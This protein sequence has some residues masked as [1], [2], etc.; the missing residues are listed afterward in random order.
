MI[1]FDDYSI[2][3]ISDSDALNL[4]D[5][6]VS[7][8]ERFQRF[9]PV[10]LKQNLTL[11]LSELFV[12]KKVKE[13]ETNEEFLFTLKANV[14]S[15]IIGLVY[16]KELDWE[17]KQGELAYCI[18]VNYEGIGLITRAVKKLIGYAFNHLGLE[19]LQI[20]VHEDNLGSVSIAKKGNFIWQRTLLNEHTPPN[21]DPLDMEL[22]ELYK[23]D[24]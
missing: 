14:S 11:E 7:N 16:I 24:D 6:M 1:L 5:L 8:A 21:E 17:K 10:T 15:T 18:D 9:F 20:I 2:D 4:C 3:K 22:Y 19:T 12:V 23:I 13:F